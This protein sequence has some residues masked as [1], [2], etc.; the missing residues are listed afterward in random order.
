MIAG[1][2]G[3]HEAVLAWIVE[4]ARRWYEAGKVFPPVPDRV[5]SD[6][7]A[8]RGRANPFFAFA[9]EYLAPNAGQHVMSDELYQFF[10]AWLKSNG[11]P[12]WSSETFASRLTEYAAAIGWDVIKKKTK[13]SLTRLSRPPA[14]MVQPAKESYQAWHGLCFRAQDEPTAESL[15]VIDHLVVPEVPGQNVP[16]SACT[17]YEVMDS[18]GTPGTT[19]VRGSSCAS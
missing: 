14:D 16:L 7:E 15:S 11:K 5:T 17:Q 19:Q 4:G 2:Q 13:R 12:G 3:Q 8:W 18:P 1:E 6:S 9:L 10:T